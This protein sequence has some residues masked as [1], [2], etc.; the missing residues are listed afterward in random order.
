[1]PPDSPDAPKTIEKMADRYLQ[2]VCA[3]QPVGPYLLG[4]YSMGAFIALEMARLVQAAGEQV[5]LLA[6]LDDGPALLR[7][8]PDWTLAELRGFLR[9]LPQWL[10]FQFGTRPPSAILADAARK[11]RVWSRRPSADLAAVLD[12]EEFSPLIRP[13]LAAH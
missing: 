1:F 10:L 11:I 7:P 9:N 13:A 4:G 6:V 3:H 8:R 5:G 2:E 12:P